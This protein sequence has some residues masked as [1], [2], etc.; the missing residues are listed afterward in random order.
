[1][2]GV[3]DRETKREGGRRLGGRE[4]KREGDVDGEGGVGRERGAGEIK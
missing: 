3:R 4:A 1:M 2:G